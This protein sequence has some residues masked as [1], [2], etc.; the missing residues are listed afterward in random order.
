M[1]VNCLKLN[2]LTIDK[3][4]KFML[5]LEPDSAFPILE[6]PMVQGIVKMHGSYIFIGKDL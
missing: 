2:I 6:F 4:I 5:A 3:G 1:A